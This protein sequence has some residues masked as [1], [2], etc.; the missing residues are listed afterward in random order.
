[1]ELANKVALVTGGNSGIGRAAA[2]LLAREGARIVIAARN[3]ATG[4]QTVAEIAAREGSAHFVPCDVRRAEDCQRTVK[5]C[6]EQFGHLDILFNNAGVVPFGTAEET[7]ENTWDQVMETNVKG[8]F[9]M[10]RAAIPVMRAQGAGVIV[11]NAS[12]WGLVGGEKAAAYCASKG[13]VVLLTK[14]MALD[15][16]REH[17][18]I[19]AVCPGE[20]YVPRWDARA[21]ALGRDVN[22]DIAAFARN[23]PLG[24]VGEVEEIAQAVLFL[25]SDRSSFMTGA[26]LSVDGGYTA[27]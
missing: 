15:H 5:A 27:M 1:M 24:R 10:S 9:L 22:D 6:I 8:V 20:T 26:T 13:A 3:A 23:I 2:L 16:A 19:N 21:K 14:A 4:R 11:N 7:D 12:D 17:I 25:A 18:R